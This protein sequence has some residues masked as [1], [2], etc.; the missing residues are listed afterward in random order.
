MLGLLG[1]QRVGKSTLA[2][3]FAEQQGLLYVQTSAS[4]VFALLGKDPKIE[5]P[6][7]ERLAIQEAILYALERQYAAARA[8][9]QLFIT[10]RTPLDLAAYMLADLQRSTLANQP[11]VAQMVANYVQRCI[12][13]TNRW[14]AA[15]VLVQPGIALVEAP[16][17]APACPAFMEHMN[18]ILGGLMLDDRLNSMHYKILRKHTSLEDRIDCINHVVASAQPQQKEGVSDG[19]RH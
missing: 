15:V 4:E 7:G 19:N 13:A 9:S 3:S 11:E 6:I 1:A 10:D 12:E 14:F 18:A 5:Y 2:N 8:V 16:G 17:K